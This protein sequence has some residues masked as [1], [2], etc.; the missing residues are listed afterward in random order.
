MI[1]GLSLP[2]LLRNWKLVA[3]A[4]AV[5]FLLGTHTSAYLKG[6]WDYAASAEVTAIKEAVKRAQATAEADR[7]LA[8]NAARQK[9]QLEKQ[10]EDLNAYV[11][12]LAD[13]DRQCLDAGDVDRLRQLWR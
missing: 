2:W 3:G 8:L 10:I 6:R 13:R 9:E 12:G 5:V 1:G 11:E 4:A 7:K